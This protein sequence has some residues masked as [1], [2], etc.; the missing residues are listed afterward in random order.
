MKEENKK[1]LGS[2]FKYLTRFS[3]I[4]YNSELKREDSLV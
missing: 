4:K 1:D 3:E 2:M